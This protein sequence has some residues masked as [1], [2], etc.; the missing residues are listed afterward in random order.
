MYRLMS[1]GNYEE[2]A[3]ID[4]VTITRDL[5]V[6]TATVNINGDRITA[7]GTLDDGLAMIDELGGGGLWYSIF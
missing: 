2:T 5:S 7:H 3:W 4:N 1:F 6:V